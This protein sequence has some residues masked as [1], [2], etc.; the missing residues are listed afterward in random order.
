MAAIE[1]MAS[2]LF[3]ITAKNR[4]SKEYFSNGIRG[5]AFPARDSGRLAEQMKKVLRMN[6]S[7]KNRIIKVNQSVVERCDKSNTSQKLQWVYKSEI[8]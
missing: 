5:L 6:E 4:A 7:E 3:L 2:G 1:A 8:M